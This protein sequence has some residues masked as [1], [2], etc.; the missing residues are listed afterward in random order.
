[1][2]GHQENLRSCVPKFWQD[3][4]ALDADD[5]HCQTA[6]RRHAIGKNVTGGRRRARSRDRRAPCD[7]L[8]EE[9]TL[10]DPDRR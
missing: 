6:K 2:I 1:M 8:L 3:L 4:L 10:E 5:L 7:T 9:A